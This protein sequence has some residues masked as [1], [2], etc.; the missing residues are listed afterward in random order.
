M[1]KPKK[2][3]DGSVR[4]T[5]E[6]GGV[7]IVLSGA[8]TSTTVAGIRASLESELPTSQVQGITLDLAAVTQLDASGVS[9]AVFLSRLAAARGITFETAGADHDRKLLIDLALR[10][11]GAQ[12][13][14]PAISAVRVV[15]IFTLGIGAFLYELVSF[16]GEIALV[17]VHVVRRPGLLRVR[18]TINFMAR[19]GS[20]AVPVVGLLGLLIGAII[21]F[22]TYDP[23]A[24]YGATLQVADVVGI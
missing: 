12:A 21:A 10:G 11:Q 15:G 16:I 3:P 9:V 14:P 1:S 8:L 22:Q 2:A 19:H 6:S 4:I 18:D 20:D 23:L 24:K 5:R 13:L 7:R 17:L